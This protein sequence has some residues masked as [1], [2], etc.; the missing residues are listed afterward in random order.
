MLGVVAVVFFAGFGTAKVRDGHNGWIAVAS[1]GFIGLL[2]VVLW[3][4]DLVIRKRSR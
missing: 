1:L 2:L 3:L 4:E